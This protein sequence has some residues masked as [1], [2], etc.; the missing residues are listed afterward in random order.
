MPE[1]Y[2]GGGRWTYFPKN[3]TYVGFISPFPVVTTTAVASTP[4]NGYVLEDGVTFYVAEDGVTFYVQE[5]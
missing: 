3:Y 5:N 2:L 4:V 1:F